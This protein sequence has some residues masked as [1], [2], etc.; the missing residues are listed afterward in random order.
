MTKGKLLEA[1]AI[2]SEYQLI[3]TSLSFSLAY[4]FR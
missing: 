3:G 1:D 2:K 4:V